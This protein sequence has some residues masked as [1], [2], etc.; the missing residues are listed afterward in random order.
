[1]NIPGI[2]LLNQQLINPQISDVH[3]LVSWMGMLQAQDYKMMRW[4]VGIRMRHPSMKAFREAY[5]AG[6]IIRTHLFRC[7]W[8]IVAAE[9]VRWML[10]LCSDKNKSAINGYMAYRGD[11]IGENEY[12]HTNNLIRQI[13]AGHKSMTKE[14]LIRQLGKQGV[15]SNAHKISIYLR[16]AEQEGIICSGELDNCQ[17]T[18]ALLDERVPPT[19][20]LTRDES[21]TLLAQKYFRSHSPATIEDFVWWSNLNIGECKAAVATIDNELIKKPHNGTVYYIHRDCRIKGLRYKTLLLPPYDEYLLGY[22]TRHHV[23]EDE[24]RHRAYS[25]NGLF[26]PV[27]ISKGQI[28]GNWHPKKSAV[29]FRDEY[30]TDINNLLQSY[31]NF[32][33]C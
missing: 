11:N 9:D 13:L 17:N 12:E 8:Q 30:A 15:T 19:K 22:K 4:A 5:D 27:I 28:V 20:E 3:D 10:K 21:I 32:M 18:Y 31:H 29:F 1:M 16:R 14:T 33:N 6:K 26:Y 23:I 24:F 2:R 25:N 7:T